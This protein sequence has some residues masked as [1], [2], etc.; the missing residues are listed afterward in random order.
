MKNFTNLIIK[1][2]AVFAILALLLPVYG[3]TTWTQTL[4]TSL[5]LT[6]LAYVIGDLWILPKFGN[7]VAVLAD[8]GL[9]ALVIW[10]MSEALPQFNVSVQGIWVTAIVIGIVE[11][12]FHWYLLSS[13]ASGKRRI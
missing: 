8:L 7:L 3:R 12:V 6:V 11:A 1:G 9:G 5:V 4:V 13:R 10:G 2:I